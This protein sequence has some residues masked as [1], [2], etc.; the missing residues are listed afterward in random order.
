MSSLFLHNY[1]LL[2]FWSPGPSEMIVLAVVALMLYGGNL[3]EVAR[4]WGKT[5]AEFRRGLTGFQ[6]EL[7]SVIYSEPEKIAYQDDTYRDD[8]NYTS[9]Y[10]ESDA[11]QDDNQEQIDESD[12]TVSAAGTDSIVADKKIEKETKEEIEEKPAD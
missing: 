9:G 12:K 1:V 8:S 4:S 2:A 10:E 3:P 6:S 7:N 5:F 11:F